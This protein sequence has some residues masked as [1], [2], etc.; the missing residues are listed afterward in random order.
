MVRPILLCALLGVTILA[1]FK[2]RDLAS[3]PQAEA[4]SGP[5][6][7]QL[8]VNFTSR[9]FDPTNPPPEMPPLTPPEAAQCDSEFLSSGKVAGDT[10]QLDATHAMVTVTRI[11]MTLQLNIAIWLPAGASQH[12]IEHENG[13][14]QISEAYY[15]TAD[16][17]A[18]GIASRNMGR[19][20]EISGEDLSGEAD[21]ALQQLAAE[22]TDEFRRDLNPEP[23][24]LLYESITNHGR[25]EVVA[26]EAAA[27][28]IKNIGIESG[29]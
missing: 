5:T 23:A 13:H 19:Q 8:P 16:E 2:W 10:R 1:A 3:R 20:V 26:K 4:S 21:K 15:Q 9:T 18:R 25:N 11:N 27:H 24:Q 6:V 7:V 17:L 28:A 29:N 14:R 12:V 22:I